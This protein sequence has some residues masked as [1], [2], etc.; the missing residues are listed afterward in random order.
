MM[1]RRRRGIHDVKIIFGSYMNR[2]SLVGRRDIF[3][4]DDDAPHRFVT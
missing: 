3:E 4:K 2:V 1:I